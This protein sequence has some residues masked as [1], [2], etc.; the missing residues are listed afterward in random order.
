M[1]Y[2]HLPEEPGWSDDAE[3]LV[4]PVSE[5]SEPGCSSVSAGGDDRLHRSD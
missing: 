4:T 1:A 3:P 2:H 5:G